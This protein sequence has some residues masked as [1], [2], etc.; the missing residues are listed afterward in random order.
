MRHVSRVMV[1]GHVSWRVHVSRDDPRGVT[2]G[3]DRFG[4]SST[5]TLTHLLQRTVH[6]RSN[7]HCMHTVSMSTLLRVRRYAP[8]APAPGTSLIT[9]REV[10]VAV[11]VW[12][13]SFV[14]QL[15]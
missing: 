12:V 6:S 7:E 15:Y 14:A 9:F 11:A 10:R 4:R 2:F 13:S 3:M 5:A 8:V 1:D